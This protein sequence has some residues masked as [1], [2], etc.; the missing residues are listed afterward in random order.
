DNVDVLA[1]IKG[2]Y[3]EDV[4]FSPIVSKPKEHKAFRYDD[5]ARLLYMAEKGKQLLCI[6]NVKVEG[7]AVRE[8]VISEA[9]TLLAHLGFRKTYDYLREFVW[10]KT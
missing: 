8:I 1:E 4:L 7:R 3:S 9:H 10:W 2:R 6:P 5:E